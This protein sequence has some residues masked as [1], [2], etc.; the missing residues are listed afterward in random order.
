[1]RLPEYEIHVS[2]L[3]NGYRFELHGSSHIHH[4]SDI[5]VPEDKM[6]WYTPED[7]SIFFN[8]SPV[9]PHV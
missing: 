9:A 3:F 4:K 6:Y 1:M 8:L 2:R 7:N 5:G